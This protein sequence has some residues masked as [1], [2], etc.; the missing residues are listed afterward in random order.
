MQKSLLIVI[1]V[2][3]SMAKKIPAA[4]LKILFSRSVLLTSVGSLFLLEV[5][6]PLVISFDLV[7]QHR[8]LHLN[9]K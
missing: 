6:K 3:Q 1:E 2:E 4:Y 7:S 8:I 9:I 5:S